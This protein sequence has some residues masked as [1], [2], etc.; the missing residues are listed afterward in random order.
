[1]LGSI[2]KPSQ[3]DSKD[4]QLTESKLLFA[5][6]ISRVSVGALALSLITINA[7]KLSATIGWVYSWRR[8]IGPVAKQI[9]IISFSTQQNPIL[10]AVA[11]SYVL[12][13]FHDWAIEWFSQ[14]GSSKVDGNLTLDGLTLRIRHAIASVS[15]AISMQ[16]SYQATLAIS[17]RCGAQGLFNVNMMS[18]MQE[19]MRGLAIAEGDILGVSIRLATELLLNRYSLPPP[20][21]PTSLLAR[22]EQGLLNECREIMASSSHHRSQL[23]NTYILPKCQK[24]VEAIGHRMAYDAAVESVKNGRHVGPNGAGGLIPECVI[25]LFEASIIRLDEG[26]YIDNIPGFT[27]RVI[28]NKEIEALQ[29]MMEVA[30]DLIDRWRL[31]ESGYVKA[32]IRSEETWGNFVKSLEV[33]G[34]QRAKPSK[35][36]GRDEAIVMARL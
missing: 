31:V 19:E 9:P 17:N 1:M 14:S 27:R 28:E 23:T 33:F 11:Q 5:Q 4:L 3:S 20:R 15:K 6:S 35:F 21:D 2:S 22:H 24:I 8:F 30:G 36:E 26:W 16:F 25:D 29:G 10:T 7:L 18:R 13:A 32:P 34:G 12:D